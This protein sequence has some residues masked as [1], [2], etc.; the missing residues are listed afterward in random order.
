MNKESKKTDNNQLLEEFKEFQSS[1]L[2]EKFQKPNVQFIKQGAQLNKRANDLVGYFERFAENLKIKGISS[3]SLRTGAGFLINTD[4]I[5]IAENK[6]DNIVEVIDFD[7]VRNNMLVIGNIPPV[8]DSTLHWFLYRGL[9]NIN[10]IIIIE[11]TEVIEKFQLGSYPE[12]VYKDGMFNTNFALKVL[13]HAKES[14]VVILNGSII[15]G[16]L[17]TGRTLDDNFNL[18]QSNLKK[19]TKSKRK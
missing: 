10:G 17:V 11:N 8:K 6:K 2:L 14:E 5:E 12:F 3:V 13:E 16:V 1:T 7:P 9:A 19:K 18:I 15:L 4:T